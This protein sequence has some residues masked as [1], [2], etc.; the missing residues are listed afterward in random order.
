MGVWALLLNFIIIYIFML[1]NLTDHL[2]NFATKL[3]IFSCDCKTHIIKTFSVCV[4][5]IINTQLIGTELI[6]ATYL[7]QFWLKFTLYVTV[8][9]QKSVF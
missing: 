5:A 4:F 6:S 2:P 7:L 1:G 3:E 9:Q 8:I